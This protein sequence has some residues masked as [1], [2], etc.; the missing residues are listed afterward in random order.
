M[1]DVEYTGRTLLILSE[2][3]SP[4]YRVIHVRFLLVSERNERSDFVAADL[5]CD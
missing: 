1:T 2:D 3:R 4:P 5:P